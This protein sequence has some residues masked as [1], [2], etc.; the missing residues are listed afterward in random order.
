M[1]SE[2]VK[3]IE[4]DQSKIT[5]HDIDSKI[6]KEVLNFI[7]TAEI[8]VYQSIGLKKPIDKMSDFPFFSY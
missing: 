3:Y 8:Q 5:L 2:N 7:Y 4:S 1:F 6:L